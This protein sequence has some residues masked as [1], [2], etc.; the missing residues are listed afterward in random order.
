M[1]SKDYE[2]MTVALLR[3]ELKSR[4]LSSDGKKAD[5]IERLKT[6]DAEQDI[7]NTSVDT[8]GLPQNDDILNEDDVLGSATEN[9]S[10]DKKT[11]D[12]APEN[13]H[14]NE[15]STNRVAITSES[16]STQSATKSAGDIASSDAKLARAQRFGLPVGIAGVTPGATTVDA[17][18]KRADRFGITAPE[19]AGTIP[20]A[21][22]TDEAKAK[23]AARFGESI[24]KKPVD[25]AVKEKLMKR[26]ARFGI[27]VNSEGTVVGKTGGVSVDPDQLKRRAE[28]FGVATPQVE[29]K[30]ARVD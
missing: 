23:R 2:K 9:G 19:A 22:V 12:E 18:V 16:E 28:R 15:G 29:E 25:D 24:T 21:L 11:T 30:K 26:A 8:T 5:L 14:K 10:S 6:A 20:A 17:K 7:L 27:P 13:G 4:G 1:S 3:D